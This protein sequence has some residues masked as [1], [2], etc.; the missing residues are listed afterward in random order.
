MPTVIQV[1]NRKTNVSGCAEAHGAVRSGP[2]QVHRRGEIG[3]LGHGEPGD[4][5]AEGSGTD[6]TGIGQP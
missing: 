2:V 4:D 6:S 3:D 1:M 5:G